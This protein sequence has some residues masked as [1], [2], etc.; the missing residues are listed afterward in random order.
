MGPVKYK[1]PFHQ[2]KN[3]HCGDLTTVTPQRYFISWYDIYILIQDPIRC[4][5]ATPLAVDM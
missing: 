2:Y 5:Q 3:T 1:I 4:N